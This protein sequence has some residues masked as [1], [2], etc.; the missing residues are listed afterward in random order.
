MFD[1]VSM[2]ALNVVL[3]SLL[4]D[5]YI[6]PVLYSDTTANGTTFEH[7]YPKCFLNKTSKD[8]LHNIF[9]A[10]SYFN[11]LR[12]NYIFS[13][14]RIGLNLYDNYICHDRRVFTPRDKDKGIIARALLYMEDTYQLEPM[15]SRRILLKW[16]KKEP[17]CLREY[18]RNKI[19]LKIQGRENNYITNSYE[20]RGD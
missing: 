1:I 15:M 2:K 4:K 7:I 11:S 9:L 17:P 6:T 12:S 5:C 10:D 3:F 14:K 13:N 19:I 20:A 8:D 18:I 16:C